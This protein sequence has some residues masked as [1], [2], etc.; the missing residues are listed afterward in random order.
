MGLWL[1]WSR[2]YQGAAKLN[3]GTVPT[4]RAMH[5]MYSKETKIHIQ[6]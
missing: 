3:D 1:R 5:Y 2:F 6:T 4:N